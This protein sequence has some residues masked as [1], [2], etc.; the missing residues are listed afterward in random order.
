MNSAAVI[1]L[2]RLEAACRGSLVWN[3]VGCR[4]RSRGFGVIAALGI[5]TRWE[6]RA[7]GIM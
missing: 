1:A 3:K 6:A 2:K 4:R 7:V 5:G